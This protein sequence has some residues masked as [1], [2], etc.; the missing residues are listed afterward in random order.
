MISFLSNAMKISLWL[1]TYFLAASDTVVYSVPFENFSLVLVTYTLSGFLGP[2]IALGWF[3]ERDLHPWNAS[4]PL[5]S[6]WALLSLFIP[7]GGISSIPLASAVYQWTVPQSIL[8]GRPL[9]R[10]PH[11]HIQLA[12]GH[13][14]SCKFKQASPT[15]LLKAN[16]NFLHGLP[17]FCLSS[18]FPT[19]VNDDSFSSC[20]VRTWLSLK[21]S[22]TP[23]LLHPDNHQ[24]V[25]ISPLNIT[26]I[27]PILFILIATTLFQALSNS[28]S[29]QQ[30]W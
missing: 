16:N 6:A 10:L 15:H 9:P 29:F 26:W 28:A 30:K 24:L 27:Y 22:C 4:V 8:W 25:P 7:S 12:L 18:M 20:H 14:S 3:L 23:L 17:L 1:F 5:C 13:R 21:S 2:L 19:S 11:S